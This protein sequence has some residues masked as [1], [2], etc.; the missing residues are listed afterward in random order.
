MEITMNTIRIQDIKD[1]TLNRQSGKKMVVL[2]SECFKNMTVQTSGREAG[3]LT[4]FL[5]QPGQGIASLKFYGF[6]EYQ[7]LSACIIHSTLNV[8]LGTRPIKR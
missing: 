5:E 1:N 7:I 6:D 3:I 2:N 4:I 8:A